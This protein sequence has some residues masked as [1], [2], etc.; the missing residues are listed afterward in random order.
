MKRLGWLLSAALVFSVPAALQSQALA[1]PVPGAA[2]VAT[3]TST[4][5]RPNPGA[6]FNLPRSRDKQWRLE[7]QVVAAID[8]AHRG[9]YIKFSIF[10]F[11]RKPVA[12]A[13]LRAHHRGV[14]VRVLLNDHQFTGAQRMLRNALTANR[15]HRSWSYMCTHGCRSH[16][17]VL[18]SKFYL[19]SHTGGAHY[20]SM[21]GSDNM[22]GNAVHNQ[23]ND[24]WTSTPD[25]QTFGWFNDLFNQMAKDKPSGE[26]NPPHPPNENWDA[27]GKGNSQATIVPRLTTPL[28]AGG[29]LLQAI[30]WPSYSASNDPII[31]ILDKVRCHYATGTGN[32]RTTVRVD[33]HAWDTDRGAWLAK[34]FRSLYAQGCNVQLMYGFAGA[35]VRPVLGKRTARGYIPIRSNG[36]DTNGDGQIDLYS[37]QKELMISGHYGAR[38]GYKLAITG[39]SNYDTYG[40]TGDEIL[41]L[42]HRT[43]AYDAYVRN[44]KYVWRYRSHPARYI[45]H[46]TNMRMSTQLAPDTL[47]APDTQ[48]DP[49]RLDQGLLDPGQ[50]DQGQLPPGVQPR[51]LP[52][53]RPAGPAWEGD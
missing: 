22:T 12:Q 13:L 6:L 31:D 49:G 27:A 33:M 4:V 17:D 24:L 40:L 32:G 15:T 14:T 52:Q 37:H 36:Y 45:P 1:A 11:D 3:A 51:W 34:K 7:R 50:M 29:L 26:Q 42:I 38:K 9:S 43:P 28:A 21:V 18:H 23:Y 20:V 48:H 16:G 46:S 35:K 2:P 19:F 8:H 39:S 44:F 41:F 10:S 25:K 5:W 53:P 30:P 47:L